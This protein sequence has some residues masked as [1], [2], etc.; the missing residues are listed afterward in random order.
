MHATDKSWHNYPNGL[1]WSLH[2]DLCHLAA[3]GY[4]EPFTDDVIRREGIRVELSQL[5]TK[6]L[7]T[8]S[9]GQG[10]LRDGTGQKEKKNTK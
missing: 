1:Q 2:K 8:P 9:D 7:K 3:V 5:A 6:H 10:S 4:K